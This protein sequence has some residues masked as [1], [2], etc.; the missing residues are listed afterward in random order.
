MPISHKDE[1]VKKPEPTP[2]PAPL[3]PLPKPG[4]K[5][6]VVGQPIDEEEQRK[7]EEAERERLKGGQK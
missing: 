5:D 1:P 6:Y 4:D 3:K 7:T 2:A